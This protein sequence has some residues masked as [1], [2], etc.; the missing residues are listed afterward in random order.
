MGSMM[1]LAVFAVVACVIALVTLV[2]VGVFAFILKRA[3]KTSQPALS[4]KP[5]A[6]QIAGVNLADGIDANERP[7]IQGLLDEL[8]RENAARESSQRRETLVQGVLGL[9][10]NPVLPK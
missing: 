9:L 8:E 7:I 2:M 5:T 1:N 6:A 4:A 10:L 3:L